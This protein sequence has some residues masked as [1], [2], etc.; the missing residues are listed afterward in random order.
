MLFTV[1]P[2]FQFPKLPFKDKSPVFPELE[3]KVALPE[4]FTHIFPREG[5]CGLGWELPTWAKRCRNTAR[6]GAK[7]KQR[8]EL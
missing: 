7:R 4:S 5:T 8:L 6:L 2:V 1:T 3:E